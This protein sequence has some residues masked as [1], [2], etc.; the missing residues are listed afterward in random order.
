[1]PDRLLLGA[2]LWQE[3]LGRIDLLPPL[4]GPKGKI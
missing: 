4:V 1:M 2:S 3:H